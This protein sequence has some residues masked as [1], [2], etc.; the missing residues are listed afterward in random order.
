MN[1][2]FT[3]NGVT[4]AVLSIRHPLGLDLDLTL[5]L[6]KNNG[7]PIDPTG[8]YPQFVLLPR[9][10]GGTRPFDMTIYDA[11]N[12][13]IAIKIPGSEMADREGYGVEVYARK[14]NDVPDGT[15][16]PTGLLARGTIYT[17]GIGYATAGP[18]GPI[19]IPVV[20]GPPG[21]PGP[22]G[23]G[24]PGEPGAPGE[25][26]SVWFTGLGAPTMT[27]DFIVGDM[28]LDKSTGDVWRWEGAD[29][30]VMQ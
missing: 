28:Y 27:G 9:S 13:V 24:A 15:P 21:P 10:R 29:A 18:L 20:T 11:A 25:R 23:V 6:Q 1:Q 7:A 8:L 4:P 26:G 12:G 30:W 19:T 3:I 16:L 22:A 17:D 14:A 2:T 5:T